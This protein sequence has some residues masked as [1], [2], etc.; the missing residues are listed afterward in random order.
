MHPRK[1]PV[2]SLAGWCVPC[3]TQRPRRLTTI[4]KL[5][6]MSTYAVYTRLPTEGGLSRRWVGEEGRREERREARVHPRK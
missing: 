1:C 6:T 5:K 2:V 3:G 4:G